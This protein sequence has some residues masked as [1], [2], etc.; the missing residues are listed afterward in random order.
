MPVKAAEN[1]KL[2]AYIDSLAPE[3][4]RKALSEI[5]TIGR[6][7]LA[8]R[9]Y[10]RARSTLA[11]RWS[12]TRQEIEAFQE[13]D[14]RQALLAEVAAVIADFAFA[15]PGYTLYAN[16]RV[17]S[18]ETQI[19]KWN[20]NAS[21]G[22]AAKELILAWHEKF[23][24]PMPDLDHLNLLKIRNWLSQFKPT[25]R[26]KLAAPGL[27]RHGRANAIDFQVMQNGKFIAGTDS[28]QIESVWQKN[29]WA[30]KLKASI[31]NAGPSFKGPL[32]RPYEPWHYD[33]VPTVEG[34]TI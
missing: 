32:M 22:Q 15:N 14:E 18:L 24:E 5:P 29:G 16:T 8:L 7:L 17:R 21:V 11:D 9:S 20:T 26:A 6:K 12:W 27:T 30:I 34:D 4:A 19:R 10:L 28:R 3:Q 13:S 25:N 33:Y 1:N 2:A 31:L 23:P